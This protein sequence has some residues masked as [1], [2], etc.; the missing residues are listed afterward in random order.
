MSELQQ[1]GGGRLKRKGERAR[2]GDREVQEKEKED[3][4]RP[5]NIDETK[6]ICKVKSHQNTTI[7]SFFFILFLRSVLSSRALIDV[8]QKKATTPFTLI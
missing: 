3:G 5:S 6:T 4:T 8:K 2:E 7:E 1:R